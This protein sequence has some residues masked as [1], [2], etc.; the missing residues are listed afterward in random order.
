[1]SSA[2]W[3]VMSLGSTSGVNWT[4]AKCEPGG[5][6]QRAGCERL[7]DTGDVV[8]EHVTAGEQARQHEAELRPLADDGALDLVEQSVGGAR[9]GAGGARRP[10]GRAAAE[11]VR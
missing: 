10:A 2:V 1:M 6:G 7:G 3:P 11:A 9:G 8:E 5:G 4:R